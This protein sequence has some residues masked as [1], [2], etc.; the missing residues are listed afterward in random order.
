MTTSNT[1]NQI[2]LKNPKI[3]KAVLLF[4]GM[5]TIMGGALIS[6]DLPRIQAY[7]AAVPSIAVI[8]PFI[9]TIVALSMIIMSPFIGTL[10]DKVGKRNIFLASL[11]LYAIG[12]SGGIYLDNI[13][14]LMVS[15]VVLAVAIGI[16][17]ACTLTLAADYFHGRERHEFMGIFTAS[18]SLGGV[19]FVSA[20][21][22]LAD[23]GWRMPFILYLFSLI[24]LPFAV[25]SIPETKEIMAKRAKTVA[26]N[27][28]QA[29]QK[30][31]IILIYLLPFFSMVF[32][33][34]FAVQIPFY[35]NILAVGTSFLAGIIIAA[36]NVLQTFAGIFYGRSVGIKPAHIMEAFFLL[37]SLGFIIISLAHS[38]L[39][40]I[41]GA[42]FC[43]F[44]MGIMMAASN[45]WVTTIAPD[46]DRGKYVVALTM[47]VYLGQFLSP[48]IAM[49]VVNM[50]G[51]SAPYGFFAQV[52]MLCLG[53]F[54]IA[55]LIS[56]ISNKK[57][58]K[59][60]FTARAITD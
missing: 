53:I 54:I 10:I 3:T 38:S 1:D 35:V 43:G 8:T 37:E 28:N 32:L 51:Y 26:V 20:S 25:L 24:V 6:P 16:L 59:N 44:G 46:I 33:Y 55:V 39:L 22:Y 21:G 11:V 23:I 12:G 18:M 17:T 49:P 2:F 57:G 41:I 36:M 13:W 60:F 19:I 5:M 52:G 27:I 4:S 50:F 42:S 30:A 47:M 45:M 7:F 58:K 9:L 34:I 14:A 48:F 29:P 31:K 56:V 15:R 40:L